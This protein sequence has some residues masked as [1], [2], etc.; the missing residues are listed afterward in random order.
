MLGQM[1]V[2]PVVQVEPNADL[3][4]AVAAL[5]E[6]TENVEIGRWIELPAAVLLFLLVPGDPESEAL[7][8]LDRRQGTWYS[9]D[10]EDKQFGGYS[11]GQISHGVDMQTM[12][13][14][15]VGRSKKHKSQGRRG[16]LPYFFPT[17]RELRWCGEL[18]RA[19]FFGVHL[20]P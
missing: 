9:V 1:M 2:E 3:Q 16:G 11:I 8:V 10:F 13:W 19:P 7:Y 4:T 17:S 6:V 5:T 20:D 18:S 15:T 12:G 14:C